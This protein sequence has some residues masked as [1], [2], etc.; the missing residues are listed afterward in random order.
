MGMCKLTRCN[1]CGSPKPKCSCEYVVGPY[2]T[3]LYFFLDA[4]YFF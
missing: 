2:I 1:N 4:D 3:V